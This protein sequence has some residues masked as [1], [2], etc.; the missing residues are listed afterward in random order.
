MSSAVIDG[1]S[2]DRGGNISRRNRTAHVGFYLIGKGLPLLERAA[3]VRASHDSTLSP[4]QKSGMRGTLLLYLGTIA[5][6]TLLLTGGL[7]AMAYRNVMPDWAVALI[8][9]LS[10]L[11]VSQLAV[12]L[13]N[14][15]AT[16]L[17]TWIAGRIPAKRAANIQVLDALRSE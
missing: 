7:L 17:V 2:G 14:W 13:T 1:S 9:I 5:L 6:I 10:L 16:L 15:L 8:G 3:D 12:G 11:S 4:R